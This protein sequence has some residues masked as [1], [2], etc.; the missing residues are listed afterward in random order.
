MN[1]G[2]KRLLQKVGVTLGVILS[3][4]GIHQTAY[5]SS[6][7][8]S[9]T[10]LP[11]PLTFD[12]PQELPTMKWNEDQTMFEGHL[13]TM[14][15]TDAT[16]S[17]AGWHVS[18]NGSPVQET[19]VDGTT[20]ILPEGSFRLYKGGAKMTSN[21]GAFPHF[22]DANYIALDEESVHPIL[23]AYPAE[24]MGQFH[25]NFADDSL[26]LYV[27]N[28]NETSTYTVTLTWSITQGP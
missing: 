4:A 18:V 27:P 1:K 9:T 7:A 20:E 8:T 19:K 23:T 13:G 24:G 15:V 2:V 11:G 17:G 16:G 21:G 10:I 3:L 6:T 5:A 12:M 26:R 22:F 28:Y 14:V 25:I